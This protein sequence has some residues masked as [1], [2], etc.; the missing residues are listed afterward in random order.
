MIWIRV[1][2]LL[3]IS[4][5][6]VVENGNLLETRTKFIGKEMTFVLFGNIHVDFE[7]CLVLMNLYN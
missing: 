2:V 5:D 4:I 6:K 7:I 3:S 1:S